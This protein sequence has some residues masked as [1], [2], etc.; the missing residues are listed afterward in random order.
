M[1]GTRS[2]INIPETAKD[3]MTQPIHYSIETLD[4]NA[5]LFRVTVTVS[6]PDGKGQQFRLPAW[7]PGSYMIREFARNIVQI[8]AVCNGQPVDLDKLDKHTWQALPCQGTLTVTYDVYAWDLSVRSAHLDQ[9]HA[10]FNGS[11]VFLEVVGHETA[12]HIVD[13]RKPADPVAGSWRIATALSEHGAERYGFGTYK[14]ENY[15]ELI[16]SPVEMGNFILGRFEAFGIPHEIAI[17]GRVPNLDLE[18]IE[19]DLKKICETEI[20]FFEPETKKA[21]VSRYVFLVMV[22]KNGYGGLEHRSSTALLCSRASLPARNRNGIPAWKISEDYLQFLGLCSHE[23]FHTWNVKRI[24]PAVFAPYDLRQEAYTR[25]LWLFEGFTSY[26]DDLTIVRS[27]IIDVSTYLRQIAN[28]INNVMRGRGHLKQSIAEAS[29]DAWI[30]YYRQDENSPNALVSYYTKGSLV[31]L[32]LDMTIRLGTNHLKSLDDVMREL[33]RRYGRDFYRSG[34]RGITDPE[35]EMLIQEI[36]GLNLHEFFRQ[37]IY[38]TDI[39][40][41]KDLFASFGISMNDTADTARPGLDIRVKRSGSDCVV[42]HVHEGGTAHLAGISA[43]DVLLAIDGLRVS[44]EN[45]AASLEKQLARYSI[46]ETVSIHIFRRD[47]L[48]KLDAVLSGEHIPKYVLTLSGEETTSMKEARRHWLQL[49][50][51]VV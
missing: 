6:D 42:T 4:L 18:R 17:T 38:G 8:H 35:A 13:I 19:T 25:L 26:Y 1:A 51:H 48:M 29:F 30:K 34:N 37:Y 33:W 21:P 10:F 2:L 39:L 24:K 11:S 43:G 32:A 46:G 44:A 15:D 22:V 3:D 12:P 14:A 23:Y 20:A 7:I 50:E 9:T 40:P 27:G 28:T 31:A 36:S 45:P 41:L 16:D 5:H 49:S 47:E